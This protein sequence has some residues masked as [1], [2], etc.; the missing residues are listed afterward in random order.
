[1]SAGLVLFGEVFFAPLRIR[2]D[3][4]FVVLLI[5]VGWTD[6]TVLVDELE[7]FD[8]SQSLIDG[9][10]N[11]QVVDCDL[12]DD[13]IRIDDEESTKRDSGIFQQDAVVG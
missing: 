3:G 10:A 13:L 9:S 8:E 5:P 4:G 1:M 7:G 2:L 12:T 6:F 11:W